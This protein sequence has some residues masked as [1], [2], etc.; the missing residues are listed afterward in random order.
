VADILCRAPVHRVLDL[1]SGLGTYAAAVLQCAPDAQAVLVDRPNAASAVGA[2]LDDQGLSGRAR[3][4]G[5]DFMELAFGG[6]F[7]LVLIS[8][9]VHNLGSE[10]SLALLDRLHPALAPNARIAIKDI[11]VDDDRLAPASA[12]RF[13]VF[14]ALCTD[15]GGVFP[16]SEVAGWLETTG[17]A[18]AP[19]LTLSAAKGAYLVTGTVRA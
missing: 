9:V 3:F 7:D 5:G 14:M 4:L 10:R 16:A 18:A 11:A 13:A 1:G 17:Y 15:A 12:G 19:P 2:F 8:N 6:P